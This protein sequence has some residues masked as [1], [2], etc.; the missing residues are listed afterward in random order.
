[1]FTPGPEPLAA[2]FLIALGAVHEG[3]NV[4][5]PDKRADE[6]SGAEATPRSKRFLRSLMRISLGV[7]IVSLL[8][9]GLLF[10]LFSVTITGRSVGLS[11]VLFAL[12]L[13]VSIGYWSR[14]W[15]KKHRRR[16]FSVLL[17]LIA[18]LYLIPLL[19]APDGQG[20]EDGHVRNGF[21]DE[22]ESFPRY[23]PWNIIPEVDQVSVGMNLITLA[24]PHVD[25][26]KAERMRSL[27]FPIYEKMERDADFASLGSAMG[28]S[29]RDL[30][31]MDLR[32]GH[33][34]L[35]LPETT[36]DAPLP[37]LIYLHG[38][39]GNRKSHFWAMS[40]V[41]KRLKCA[42]IAPTFGLGN[43]EKPGGAELVVDVAREA[44]AILP[45][46]P[47]QIFLI[48]YSNGAM[49][50]TR[51]AVKAPELFAGLIYLSPVTE[52]EL[53]STP[54]F[55]SRIDDRRILFVHGG[56][57]RRIPR[58]MVENT[59]RMLKRLGCNVRST[60]YDDEDHYLVLSQMDS[61][62]D[63]VVELMSAAGKK[64]EDP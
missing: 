21:L 20:A 32:T 28:M 9:G 30:F 59:I 58:H 31:G 38:M 64:V 23:S 19:F 56:Q 63:E 61:V 15:F 52:D 47:E 62:A 27:S 7:P 29:Y 5:A 45:V 48:G 41:A 44:L 36:D 24:D 43:W 18:T 8:S 16:L 14:E 11:A 40:R 13:Y 26:E 39:G 50:V 55:Q 54:E 42:V 33:Y 57:D 46:D 25:F 3:R 34:Y 17:P 4:H 2:C 35:F 51:A 60:F 1:M 53:F 49:G 6:G 37:C 10:V 22:K 12:L